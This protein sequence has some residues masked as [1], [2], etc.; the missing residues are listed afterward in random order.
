M[1]LPDSTAFIGEARHEF[2]SLEGAGFVVGDNEDQPTYVAI[3]FVGKHVEVTVAL[4]RRDSC[5]DC[6]GKKMNAGYPIQIGASDYYSES[7]HSFLVK[8]RHYRGAFREFGNAN[9]GGVPWRTSLRSYA[10]A[11]KVLAPDIV[12]D[13]PGC[14]EPK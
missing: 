4:D 7:L 5:V 6:R 12:A 11:L 3:H 10:A 13:K 8:R 2:S 9:A 14:L 1:T